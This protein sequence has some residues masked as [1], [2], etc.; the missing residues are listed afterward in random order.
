M[1]PRP[2]LSITV[3][4]VAPAP[5]SATAEQG[6]H[7]AAGVTSA[8]AIGGPADASGA[9][10]SLGMADAGRTRSRP[11]LAQA[12]SLFA[13]PSFFTRQGAG[14]AGGGS[15]T[16]TKSMKEA[17]FRDQACSVDYALVV[18]FMAVNLLKF[19][20][21]LSSV[22][23]QAFAF[24]DDAGKYLD[25]LG[26]ILPASA[27]WQL[28]VGPMLDRYGVVVGCYVQVV[29]GILFSILSL[30]PNIK[31]QVGTFIALGLFR[32][33]M[34]STLVSFLASRFGFRNFGRL[35][36]VTVFIGGSFAALQYPLVDLSMKTFDGDFT[37]ANLIILG[38]SVAQ[39]GFPIYVQILDRRR[40]ARIENTAFEDFA[41]AVKQATEPPSSSAG[42]GESAAATASGAGAAN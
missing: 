26:I 2:R 37:V 1:P 31:V 35:A 19:N 15:L 4:V 6:P 24:S 36:G 7:A 42:A 8:S 27:L 30:I 23:N 34:F 41:D 25:Y 5:T 13:M 12:P 14:T 39:L 16:R 10:P 18:T 11:K 9:A 38:L 28:L 20:F 3:P 33:L 22:G 32:S 21:Y 40:S 17:S 29:V